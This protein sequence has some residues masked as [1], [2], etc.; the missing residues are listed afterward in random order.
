MKNVKIG[1]GCKKKEKIF[2]ATFSSFPCY[3][4]QKKKDKLTTQ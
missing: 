1:Q 4:H 3:E 2:H